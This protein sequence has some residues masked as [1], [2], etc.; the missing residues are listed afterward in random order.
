MLLLVIYAPQATI[1]TGHWRLQ[2]SSLALALL[3]I[4][5]PLERNLL[6]LQQTS[7]EYY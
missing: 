1:A 2:E 5:A 3:D 6:Q 7:V 4:I